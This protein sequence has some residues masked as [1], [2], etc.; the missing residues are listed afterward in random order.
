[1]KRNSPRL[2]LH[3]P[4][5][6]QIKM[7][8]VLNELCVDDASLVSLTVEESTDGQPIS[9]LTGTFDQ[10]ALIGLLRRI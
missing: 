1:M 9:I 6:Y 5:T 4:E 3:Q 2:S 8:G 7:P 10:A